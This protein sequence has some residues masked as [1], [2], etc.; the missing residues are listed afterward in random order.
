MKTFFIMGILLTILSCTRTYQF[1]YTKK[2]GIEQLLVT[3]AVDQAF[4]KM[5]VDLKGSRVFVDVACLMRDE[6]SYIR[7]AFTHWFLDAGVFVSEYPW[8]ADYIVSVLVKVAGTDGDQVSIGVPSFPVPM[9]ISVT[10]PA[11]TLLGQMTQEGRVE[12]E[13][14]IYSPKTGIKEKI[15]SLKGDSYYKKYII[16]FVPFTRKNIP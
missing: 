7:K 9:T 11:L 13:V 15:P 8:D 14:M 3:R 16:F 5:T 2:S 6:Q 10:I 1:T 4:E 12:M